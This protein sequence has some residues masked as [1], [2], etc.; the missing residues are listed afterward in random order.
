MEAPSVRVKLPK[1]ELLPICRIPYAPV[2]P[3]FEVT[4]PR[5]SILLLFMIP[6]VPVTPVK[7]ISLPY[8]LILPNWV[9]LIK[10]PSAAFCVVRFT[11]LKFSWVP[12]AYSS[13][14]DSSN[15][16]YS[17]ALIVEFLLVWS[18]CTPIMFRVPAADVP[19]LSS[20]V[21]MSSA[22]SNMK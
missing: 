19:A 10:A 13:S 21:Y 17:P 9:L 14:L 16:V 1:L 7:I 4:L 2:M 11:S 8:I 20:D 6:L 22:L 15:N 12:I 18:L 5:M 3:V